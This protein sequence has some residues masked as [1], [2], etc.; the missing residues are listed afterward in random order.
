MSNFGQG[1]LAVV[2]GFVGFLI[3]GPTGAAFGFQAGLGA[4]SLLFPTQLPGVQGPRLEDLN[5]AQ[6]Q[7]GAPVPI[8]FGTIAIP[9]TVMWLGPV[10]EHSE[11]QE[12][13]GKGAPEQEITTYSYT[14]SIAI[15]L[16]EGPIGGVL[17][18]WENGELV[19]DAREKQAEETDEDYAARVQASAE[20]YEK[21]TLHLGDEEQQPDP[22]IEAVEGVGEVPAFAGLAYVVFPDRLLRDDQGRRHPS[23][24]F[25]VAR[26]GSTPLLVFTTD[27][28][29]EKPPGLVSA[30]VHCVGGGGGGSSG[31]R[32]PIES[33]A[34]GGNGGGG[35]GYSSAT[36]LADDLPDT[37]AVTVGRGGLGGKALG[38]GNTSHGQFAGTNGTASSFGELLTAGGGIA[39]GT[40]PGTGG[41]GTVEN[42]GGGGEEGKA[43]G[44]FYGGSDGGSCNAAA[45][46]GG[47]GG[48]STFGGGAD[49]TGAGG[50]GGNGS[51]AQQNPGE[52]GAG[53]LNDSEQPSAGENGQNGTYGGGGGGGG[54]SGFRNV[55]LGIFAF[56]GGHG[57]NGGLW[58]GGGG[59]G[60]C[61]KAPG[62]D[63]AARAGDGGN[64]ADG[65]VI[66]QHDFSAS[67]TPLAEIVRALCERVGL[68]HVDVADLEERFVVGYAIARQTSARAAIDALRPV[69]FFD[70]VCSGAYLRFPTRGKPIIATLSAADLGAHANGE[71]SPP[72]V[73]TVRKQDV[74]LPRR[75]RFHYSSP[76]RDYEPGEQLSPARLSTEST[77]DVDLDVPVAITDEMAAQAVEVTWADSWYSRSSHRTALGAE[78]SHLEPAD[79]IGVPIDGRVQRCRIVTI[80]DSAGVLRRLELVRDDDGS[81][82]SSAM[83]DPPA[84]RPQLMTV[85]ADT[86]LILLDLPALREDDDN[87]GIYAAC[88]RSGSGTWKG[89]AISRSIDGGAAFSPVA[90]IVN[91][92][93]VGTVMEVAPPDQ[94]VTWQETGSFT[95]ELQTGTLESRTEAAVLN[96]AN[97]AA[98]GAHGRWEIVQFRNAEQISSTR[99]RISGLLRGRRGTEYLIG[100]AQPGDRFVLVS[101]AGIVRLPLQTDVVGAECVYRATS[102]GRPAATGIEQTFTGEGRA[103]KPFSP[104]HVHVTQQQNGDFIITAIRRDRLHQTLRSGV[105]LPLS[106]HEEAYELDVLDADLSVVR[107]IESNTLSV[108]YTAAQQTEDFGAPIALEELQFAWY[109]LSALV[110]RGVPATYPSGLTLDP[111]T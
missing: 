33:P 52:G 9:G 96:G 100:S 29:W 85:I 49:R 101:G 5:T 98:I 67:L 16:C 61:A 53:S 72:L 54:A 70:C 7:V 74:E 105:E 58:G 31:M 69:G 45:G 104:V 34:V 35:G 3:G 94:G 4:G 68:S 28:T 55:S 38:L 47:G 90:S 6:A 14:Q 65:V 86:E 59:G 63:F 2:G 48:S 77:N 64:G 19:F 39:G 40:G 25:E 57:G 84:R 95:I 110:G 88:I 50:N 82:T 20:Y 43:T 102:I 73:T 71:E 10:V 62:G 107:T 27:G 36:F 46:G 30:T 81:Y 23:F 37:V 78:W 18:I 79:C 89:A 32:Q 108:T 97:A 1:A 12:V 80:D 99:W 44:S 75:L 66:V 91:E 111:S 109:Q 60:G 21:L 56:N 13:G 83:A 92:A 106:E 41:T 103:L 87:A 26:G 51:V 17:R 11:T 24:R 8:V 15:G 76:A 93:V 22:T 42:G